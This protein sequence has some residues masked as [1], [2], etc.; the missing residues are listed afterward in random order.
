MNKIKLKDVFFYIIV[1][2]AILLLGAIVLWSSFK[3]GPSMLKLPFYSGIAFFLA[4][5]AFIFLCLKLNLLSKINNMVFLIILL[6][7]ALL[8]RLLWISCIQTQPYSDFL[9]MHN[10]GV[11]VS[12]GD[13]K[14]FV[15]FY[16][17]FPF[18][19][20]FGML[21][22]GLYHIFGTGL[23]VAKLFNV[24][25]SALLVFIIYKG[26]KMLYGIK[27]GRISGLLAALWPADIM[28]GSVIASEHLFLVLF[29]GALLLSL[30]FLKK[31][32]YRNYKISN[33]NLL[34]ISIGL[35]TAAAQLI[36]PMAMLVLPV[37]AVFVLIYKRYRANTVESIALNFKS[38]VLMIAC[39]VIAINLINLPLQALS[40]VDASRSDA[41]F[42]LMIGTNFKANGMF[43]IE[44]FS[45]IEKNNYDIGKIHREA[46]QI[47]FERIT[48]NPAKLPR[49]FLKKF[50]IL[51]GNENYGYYWSTI[52]AGSAPAEIAVKSYPRLFYGA[53]Q[54][55]Y[56]LILMLSICTCLYSLREKRYDSLIILMVF[57]GIFL[58]YMLLEVQSRYHLPVMPLFIIFSTGFLSESNRYE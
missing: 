37:F 55:F 31:Y 15:D 18:K 49:L 1:W 33:G 13:F 12:R 51:W 48:N 2:G 32:T 41:G 10:Y 46:R 58:S 57:G 38:I 42:N 27:A 28:Y 4:G 29:T 25:L 9:H 47:A 24:F 14:G 20:G 5:P 26:G 21:L 52:S 30:R 16:A 7:L 43:N 40:G 36:R 17:A 54:G 34:I 45:I 19:I 56:I 11:S 3:S 23:L 39:Y 6:L 50:E 22:G 44:D 8:P 35:L 53:A